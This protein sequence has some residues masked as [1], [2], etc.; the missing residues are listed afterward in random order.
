MAERAKQPTWVMFSLLESIFACTAFILLWIGGI[1]CNFIKFTD[2]S[3]TSEPISMQ[4][5]IWYYQFWSVVTS[6]D[7]TFLFESCHGY[8][9]YVELDATWKAARAFSVLTLIFGLVVFIVS[10]FS[11]CA[12]NPDKPLTR[13]WM[14]PAYLLTAIFQGLM[15]LLLS[16]A[17]C[18]NNVLVQNASAEYYPMRGVTFPDTCS[19]ATGAK[20]TISATV[21]WAAAGVASYMAHRAE[22]KAEGAEAQASLTEPLAP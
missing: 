22:V 18:T 11:A 2:T 21:F 13:G 20:L 6:A 9:D 14:A 17:A 12:P 16:S 7:G 10:L 19:I 8:P 3:G 4:F 15:L 1:R 5:G